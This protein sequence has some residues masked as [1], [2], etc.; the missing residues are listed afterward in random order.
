M[1]FLDLAAQR[2]R[3]GED[4]DRAIA[5]VLAHGQFIMGPEVLEFEDRL[6]RYC[7]VRHAVSCS[8]GTDALLLS[9]L[10]WSVRSGDA[11][12]VPAFTF[13]ATAGAVALLGAT[14]VFVDVDPAT[15]NIDPEILEDAITDAARSRLNPVGI[16]AVDLFGRPADYRSLV[17]IARRSGLWLLADAAQSF[18][19]RLEGHP[20]GE[21]ADAT[22]LSFFPSKPLGC[23]G[24]GGAVL[25]NDDYLADLLRSHR[26]H[27]S[28][29]HKYENLRVGIN[30]RLDTLQAAILLEKLKIF[31]D[32]LNGR[33]QI[34]GRYIDAL[35]D[36]VAVPLR[37]DNDIESAWAQFTIR[38]DHRQVLQDELRARGIPTA[39][40]YPK[41]LDQQQAFDRSPFY[42]PVEKVAHRLANEVISLPSHAYLSSE[43]QDTVIAAIHEVLT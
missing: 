29:A 11:V 39:V 43:D 33:S 9:L 8:S 15:Y 18:G 1:K 14:P 20:V 7:G 32:E 10:S 5:R 40:Y 2:V 31:D 27:G 34:A 36:V 41:S 38:T 22:A 37:S 21:L 42:G 4:I 13:A 35:S 17:D 12:F 3:I 6:S 30:G 23:Y 19:A 16:I 28:G 25:T 26:V 24:D